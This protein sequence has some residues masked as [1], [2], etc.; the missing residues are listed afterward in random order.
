V[1]V[2][3]PLTRDD[4]SPEDPSPSG[5]LLVQP[6]GLSM[7]EIFDRNVAFVWRTLRHFGISEAD[8][9]DVCQEVFVVVHRKIGG[10]EGRSALRTW[11]YGICFRVA[12]DHRSRAYIRRE[13]PVSEPPPHAVA[14][15]Q[16]SDCARA[17]A[18]LILESI[19]DLLDEDK[20]AV[21]V[22]YEIEGLSMREVAEAVG[23]PLQT[24]Y[25]RLQAARKIVLDAAESA[26]GLRRRV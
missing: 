22:L 25:S 6:L 2:R 9:E 16:D 17:E 19:L 5:P 24:A 20:R 26:S 13:V 3:S 14:P 7:R 8:L 12:K 18:R 4:G 23:C 15:T 1:V 21:F 10:F 11:L